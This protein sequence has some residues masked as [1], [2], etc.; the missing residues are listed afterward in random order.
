MG[1]RGEQDS[2]LNNFLLFFINAFL[3]NL[4]RVHSLL[5]LSENILDRNFLTLAYLKVSLTIRISNSGFL[6]I[7]L[8]HLEDTGPPSP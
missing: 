7:L 1:S 6:V 2:T 3:L 8:A 5:T 4:A